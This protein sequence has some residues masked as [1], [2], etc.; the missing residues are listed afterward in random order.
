MT[1]AFQQFSEFIAR[2]L[3]GGG[4][5]A[6]HLLEEDEVGEGAQVLKALALELGEPRQRLGQAEEPVLVVTRR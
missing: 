5:D 3:P 1:R 2:L 6:F 4:D